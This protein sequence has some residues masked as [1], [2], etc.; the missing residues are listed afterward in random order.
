MSKKEND[1]IFEGY[2]NSRNPQ[3]YEKMNIREFPPGILDPSGKINTEMFFRFIYDK[4]T[5]GVDVKYDDIPQSITT[6]LPPFT[7]WPM[8]IQ[9]RIRPPSGHVHRDT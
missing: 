3:N 7:E 5:E 2:M 6:R 8:H 9:T 1:L 4:S